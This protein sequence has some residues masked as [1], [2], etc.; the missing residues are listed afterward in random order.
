MHV[1]T[2]NEMQRFVR[3]TGVVGA[4]LLVAGILGL[5]LWAVSLGGLL[6][7]L[8]GLVVL[9]A[10]EG[11]ELD[12]APVE[13]T[14]EL[15]PTGRT[16]PSA[17]DERPGD[18]RSPLLRRGDGALA[19]DGTSAPTGDPTAARQASPPTEPAPSP[20][21]AKSTLSPLER[22]AMALP[23]GAL[24]D[25]KPPPTP[26]KA[27]SPDADREPP[28]SLT[29]ASPPDPVPDPG[30]S[31]V[32]SSAAVDEPPEPAAVFDE[33]PSVVN[34]PPAAASAVAPQVVD[35][36]DD[37]SEGTERPS[38]SSAAVEQPSVEATD[39]PGPEPAVVTFRLPRSVGA[40]VATVV[41]EFN[42]W[43]PDAHPMAPEDDA[44][45]A[46]IPLEPGRAYRYRYLLDGAR[47]ENDWAA[48]GYVPNEFGGDD[49]LIDL[50]R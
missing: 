18:D 44:F 34:L 47:W 1:L 22:L 10:V 45:V 42:G 20:P 48:D 37:A 21:P 36:R 40:Q 43:S 28:P 33:P 38:A 35:L 31:P 50:R 32:E 5:G 15:V 2:D 4:L 41:G 8:A 14:R 12:E 6:L 23:P 49:S 30:D 16:T 25:R 46:R 13:R 27:S 11:R 19:D 17:D 39:E 26:M 24:P 9:A 7:V 3:A 29:E